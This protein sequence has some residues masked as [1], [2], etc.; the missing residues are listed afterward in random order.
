ME[1]PKSSTY[2]HYEKPGTQPPIYVA[3][4]FSEPPWH[5]YE[6][7]YTTDADGEHVF[8]KEIHVEPGSKIQYKFRV[9]AG[10]WWVL[11][12]GAPT[13]TDGAGNTNHEMEVKPSTD[14]PTATGLT[15]HA[16]PRSGTS[17]P[18]YAKIAD[19]VADSAAILNKEKPETPV[20]DAEAGRIGYRRLTSTPIAEVANTAAEVAD[21]AKKLDSAEEV[22]GLKIFPVHSSPLETYSPGDSYLGGQSEHTP[23]LFAHECVGMYDPDGAD[24]VQTGAVDLEDDPVEPEVHHQVPASEDQLDPNKV[25]I[26]DPTIERFPSSRDEIIDTVRKLETG[27]N[28]DQAA[29]DGVPLSPVVGSSRRGTLD[30]TGDFLL[31]PI[32]VS[33]VVPRVTRRL[34]VPRSPRGSISSANSSALSLQSISE[35]DEPSPGEETRTSPVVLLSTPRRRPDV[36]APESD[37][38]EG[39]VMRDSAVPVTPKTDQDE[40]L[41][42]HDAV[43]AKHSGEDQGALL[44]PRLGTPDWATSESPRIV[45]NAAEDA[46]GIIGSDHAA[47]SKAA[48]EIDGHA[49]GATSTG[50]E[51]GNADG[52][53][54]RLRKRGSAA[55]T[56]DSSSASHTPAAVAPGHKGGWLKAFIK[57]VFVDWIGGFFGRLYGSSRRN[58]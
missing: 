27:L 33:P 36:K 24:D 39:V 9:G 54:S 43:A 17:T 41:A 11:N 12:E 48:D 22:V 25:D 45:I 3:G 5:P 8:K 7:D 2:I 31:S 1:S 50:V 20:P 53:S 47:T 32:P 49:N 55:L 37:E 21:T 19:E 6:M 30:F 42:P 4:T 44:T 40:H 34:E 56:P 46:D 35:G 23:P 29:F 15:T 13:V 14:K 52:A 26:N 16:A 58:T 38:D 51:G 57:M 10:N 18:N 28:E